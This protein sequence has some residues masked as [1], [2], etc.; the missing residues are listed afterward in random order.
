VTDKLQYYFSCSTCAKTH[1]QAS[2]ISKTFTGLYIG[3]PLKRGGEGKGSEE[4][5]RERESEGRGSS[6]FA[7]GR[8]K[9]SRR[10]HA[11][12]RTFQLHGTLQVTIL[13]PW[14]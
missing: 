10:L 7:L 9:K 6:F 8:K 5:E 12:L 13:S 11:V 2:A 1:L 4:R 3:P 14:Q